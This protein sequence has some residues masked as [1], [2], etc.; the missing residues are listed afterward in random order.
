[1]IQSTEV[2][3]APEA[4]LMRVGAPPHG[5]RRAAP[6]GAPSS[7]ARKRRRV[8]AA[9]AAVAGGAFA[10]GV[11]VGGLHVPG[12]QRSVERFASAWERGDFAAMYSE[13]SDAE[14]GRVRRGAFA[15]AYQRALDTATARRVTTGEARRAGDGYRVPVR[16]DTRIFGTIRG[17]VDVPADGDGVDWSHDLVFPGLR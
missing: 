10:I 1:M 13:L 16:I 4:T 2:T 9:G 12:A 17:T 5:V 6:H 8:L 15:A 3:T 7:R 11:V 14:R